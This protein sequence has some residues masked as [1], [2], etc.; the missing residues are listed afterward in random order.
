MTRPFNLRPG[1][2]AI[3]YPSEGI[4]GGRVTPITGTQQRTIHLL[5]DKTGEVPENV[6]V[7]HFEE[8][9][10]HHFDTISMSAAS[11]VIGYLKRIEMTQSMMRKFQRTEAQQIAWEMGE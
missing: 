8:P 11:A 10:N 5:L 6:W 9:F 1:A 3:T 7:E 4:R 2:P